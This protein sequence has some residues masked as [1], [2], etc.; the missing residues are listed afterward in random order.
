MQPQKSPAVEATVVASDSLFYKVGMNALNHMM[1]I[2]KTSF[3]PWTLVEVPDYDIPNM[4]MV[5]SG[6][7]VSSW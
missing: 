1:K 7:P 3:F 2:V 5:S 4:F 6:N